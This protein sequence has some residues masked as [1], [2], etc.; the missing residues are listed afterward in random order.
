[1]PDM[2]FEYPDAPHDYMLHPKHLRELTIDASYPYLDKSLKG[3]LEN[4]KTYFIIFALAFIL[5]PLRY[6]LKIVGKENIRNNR[7]FFK[8]GAMTIGNHVYRWDFLAIVQAIKYR[9]M[10]F[11]A[12]AENLLGPDAKLIRGAGGIPVPDGIGGIKQFNAAFDELH[13]KGKWFHCF[14]E[15]CRWDFYTPIRPFRKGA[16]S[17]AVKYNL[18]IIPTVFTYRK[19]TGLRALLG[20]KHPL[21]TLHVG[22][23]VLPDPNLKRNE[24]VSRM[25][26]E[27]HRQMVEMA[28]IVKNPWPATDE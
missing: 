5:N 1:M 3:R 11:P 19:P 6:G 7:H 16:F 23:P 15:A 14:P 27:A 18:P 2:G 25:L 8:N 20:V 22:T 17:M 13:K 26:S 9:R 10:W 24:N 4:W 21:V 28:N 12:R